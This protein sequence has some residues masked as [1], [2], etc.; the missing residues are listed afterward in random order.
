MMRRSLKHLLNMSGFEMINI[1][2]KDHKDHCQV[3]K[4]LLHTRH[5]ECGAIT[6]ILTVI[7][8]VMAT[9]I[10][11]FAASYGMMQEKTSTNSYTSAQAYEAAE[12]GMEYA[13]NY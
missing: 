10:I 6:I 5:R 7:L 2:H 1:Y 8:F 3:E 11:L 4:V 12:E 13:I 9:L